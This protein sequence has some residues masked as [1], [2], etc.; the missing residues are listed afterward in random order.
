M[1]ESLPAGHL[2]MFIQMALS[3]MRKDL[4]ISRFWHSPDLQDKREHLIS[5]LNATRQV[6]FRDEYSFKNCADTAK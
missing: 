3:Y 5:I 1:A 2:S 4:L 6:M